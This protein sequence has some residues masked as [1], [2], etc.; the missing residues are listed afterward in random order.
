VPDQQVGWAEVLAVF[1]FARL[2]TAIPITP[3]GVGVVELA[4]IT[5]LTR[6]GGDD[7]A[8]VAAVLLYRVLTYLVPIVLGAG[9]YVYWRR[10]RSWLDSAPPLSDEFGVPSPHA[11]T[12]AH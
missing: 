1:A 8:V 7:A 4:L 6:G 11:S 2:V 5:G 12:D 10:K 9:T 3:G